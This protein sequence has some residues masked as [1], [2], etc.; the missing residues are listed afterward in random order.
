[1][2]K[3]WETHIESRPEDD[4]SELMKKLNVI[5]FL[6]LKWHL[7]NCLNELIQCQGFVIKVLLHHTTVC[8]VVVLL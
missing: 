8:T 3:K 2:S 6:N 7:Y 4:C 5:F 1:M